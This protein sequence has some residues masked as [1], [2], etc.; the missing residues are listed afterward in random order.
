VL[1]NETAP[2]PEVFC[3][4]LEM[5]DRQCH[6]SSPDEDTGTRSFS[7]LLGVTQLIR[8]TDPTTQALEK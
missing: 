7:E 5:G 4:D 8:P 3:R 6:T 1:S 2:S